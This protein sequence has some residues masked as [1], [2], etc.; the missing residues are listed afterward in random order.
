MTQLTSI[1]VIASALEDSGAGP[2]AEH[3]SPDGAITLMFC[4]IA[5]LATIREALTAERVAAIVDDQRLVLRSIASRNGG[6]IAGEHEDG[7]LIVFDSAHAGLYCAIEVQRAFATTTE[8]GEHPPIQLRVGVHTGFVIGEEEHLY[9]RNVLL[10]AR[11]ATEA[12][13]AEIVVSA[14]VREYTRTTPGFR[15]TS[16]GEHH[17]RGL[18]GE[19]ELFALEWRE[20]VSGMP[21]AG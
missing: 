8:S 16:R 10:G 5:N 12:A 13:G 15:F 17:F 11:I 9:G 4:E 2:L 20:H 7:F 3:S 18:H 21:S 1:D 14:K 19:H 6:H